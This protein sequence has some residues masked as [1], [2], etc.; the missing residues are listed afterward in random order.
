MMSLIPVHSLL[1]LFPGRK[2]VRGE[3]G[4]MRR[5]IIITLRSSF[6]CLSPYEKHSEPYVTVTC[7]RYSHPKGLWVF[8]TLSVICISVSPC[9]TSLRVI[10]DFNSHQYDCITCSICCLSV[11]QGGDKHAYLYTDKNLII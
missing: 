5:D 4:W 1:Y 9:S 3:P 11:A 6:C 2:C 8:I 7:A 10:C